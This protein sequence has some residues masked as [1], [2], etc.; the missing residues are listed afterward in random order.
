[1]RNRNPDPCTNI[2]GISATILLPP[3]ENIGGYDVQTVGEFKRVKPL[4]DQSCVL[5]V[6]FGVIEID[7]IAKPVIA[8]ENSTE[9]IV[10]RGL[11]GFSLPAS[12][13]IQRVAI[14]RA[15]HT[16]MRSRLRTRVEA[17]LPLGQRWCCGEKSNGNGQGDLFHWYAPISER[18]CVLRLHHRKSANRG[19]PTRCQKPRF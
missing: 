3:V 17:Q 7:A 15:G 14:R 16:T 18:W 5:C 9:T 2:G 11:E 6:D 10:G 12:G 13:E 4:I 1:M 8:P 19:Q